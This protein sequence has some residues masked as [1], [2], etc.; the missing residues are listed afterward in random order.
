MWLTQPG[1]APLKLTFRIPAAVSCQELCGQGWDFMATSP[2][3]AG[4]WS[5]LSL[6]R[7]CAYCGDCCDFVGTAGLLCLENLEVIYCLWLFHSL[8]L[9]VWE[10]WV[11]RRRLG[12]SILRYL[13]LCALTSGGSLSCSPSPAHKVSLLRVTLSSKCEL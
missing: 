5:G 1:T 4:I 7:S 3:R 11:R 12:E 13:I 6:R 9:L 8:H 10:E 2:L